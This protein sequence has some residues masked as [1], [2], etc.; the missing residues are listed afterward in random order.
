M[1]SWVKQRK[2]I[3]LWLLLTVVLGGVLGQ[4]FFRSEDK[5]ALL[6]GVTTHGHYQI[7][8]Q[9]SACHT[10]EES[11]NVFTVSGVPNNACTAC[12]GEDLT[13][14]S[15]SH[16]VRKFRN[17]ENAVFLEHINVMECVTCHKEHNRKITGEMGVT[18]P[19]DYCAHCHQVTLDNLVSHQK[20]SYTS[21]ATAGCHNYHDN[22]AL[23]P[24][25][26]L[27]H[28]GE[29]DLLAEQKTMETA[30]LDRWIAEGNPRREALTVAQADAPIEH[31]G[32]EKINRDW[33]HTGHAAAGI[34]CS[35]CHAGPESGGWVASPD[36]NACQKCHG[37]EVSDFF[38]GKHGMRLA[39]EGLLTPMSPELARREMKPEA[40]HRRLSCNSCH[41][42]HR[43]DRQFAAWQACIQCHDDAH[44]RNYQGS[45]HY[46]LWQETG[47]GVSCATC[48]MPRVER[49]G[50]V[51]VNHNQNDNLTPNEKMLRNVCTNCHGMQFA[52]DALADRALIRANFNGRPAAGHPGIGWAAQSAIDRGDEKVIAIKKYLDSLPQPRGSGDN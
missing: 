39:H 38:K 7:E 48:H 20:L 14:F 27:K 15:D 31:S 2:N 21:C 25:F 22:I 26:L 47:V 6:P 11:D 36:H 10:R 45:R 35:D 29:S 23:A 17:P 33:G 51:V 28:Y 32:D 46:Q 49:D 50:V 1:A 9:C 34:N 3:I 40:A 4:L 8:M 43:Y 19:A 5:T 13:D 37:T 52:V 42:P 30:V 16:P 24:S 12:H 41:Q 18:I 44:T